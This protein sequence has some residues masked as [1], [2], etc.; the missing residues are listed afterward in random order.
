M[1]CNVPYENIK[2]QNNSTANIRI[3]NEELFDNRPKLLFRH[4]DSGIAS[5]NDLVENERYSPSPLT[6][7]GTQYRTSLPPIPQSLAVNHPSRKHIRT[8]SGPLALLA[9]E[10]IKK[11]IVLDSKAFGKKTWSPGVS[12]KLN[13]TEQDFKTD[14]FI[15]NDTSLTPLAAVSF[16]FERS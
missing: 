12:P 14:G 16:V 5:I 2:T 9:M 8:D 1:V 13:F 11:D 15:I 3:K 6:P 10:E 7:P 4:S